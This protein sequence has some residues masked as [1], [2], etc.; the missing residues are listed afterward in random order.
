MTKKTPSAVIPDLV[1]IRMDKST[2]IETVGMAGDHA[3]IRFSNGMR[4]DVS[5]AQLEAIV[6]GHQEWQRVESILTQL[7][8]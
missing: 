6:A 5:R 7:A 1:V 8:D 3:W 4:V 2:D